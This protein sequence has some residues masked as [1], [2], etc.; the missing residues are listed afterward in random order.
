M[1]NI[2]LKD[3]QVAN[4]YRTRDRFSLRILT[5]PGIVVELVFES[6]D[7]SINFATELLKSAEDLKKQKPA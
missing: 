7:D 1:V 6:P 4:N 2:Q 3:A 5:T